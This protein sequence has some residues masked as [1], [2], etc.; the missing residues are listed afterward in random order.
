L[1]DIIRVDYQFYKKNPL[2]YD[3]ESLYEVNNKLIET[4]EM[5]QSGE[6]IKLLLI[7]GEN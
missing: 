2:N 3:L 6:N 1:K 7:Y 5:H 4:E